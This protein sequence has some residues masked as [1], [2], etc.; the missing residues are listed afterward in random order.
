MEGG[1]GLL[2]G[3]PGPHSDAS[4]RPSLRR[5]APGGTWAQRHPASGHQPG[6]RRPLGE[7]GPLL[8]S[9]GPRVAA[10][11]GAGGP[12]WGPATSKRGVS[13]PACQRAG[14]G[15]PAVTAEGCGTA[16]A[17]TQAMA[18]YRYGFSTTYNLRAGR[19]K[20]WELVSVLQRVP[21]I[22]PLLSTNSARPVIVRL[23]RSW[24]RGW[25]ATRKMQTAMA[26]L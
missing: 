16:P 23:G 21:G 15:G 20:R 10:W 9:G 3:P 4:D 22:A 1:R 18:R 11:R 24:K 8:P 17:V 12:S 5:S 13:M 14:L 26:S 7:A 2:R 19:D 6:T 25:A